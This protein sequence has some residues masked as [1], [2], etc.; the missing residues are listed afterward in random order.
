MILGD[1]RMENTFLPAPTKDLAISIR[2]IWKLRSRVDTD[3]SGERRV[4]P[5]LGAD[6]LGVLCFASNYFAAQFMKRDRSAKGNTPA[7][8]QGRNNSSA[9]DGYDAYFGTYEL[10]ERAGTLTIHLEGSISPSNIGS[11]FVRDVRVLD[12]ELVI[13]LST[14]DADGTAI[15]RTLTFSRLE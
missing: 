15:T 7:P 2:G 4:D 5:V 13:R 11:S 12:N 1:G 6:P 10:D 8:A 14:T 9:V 3:E